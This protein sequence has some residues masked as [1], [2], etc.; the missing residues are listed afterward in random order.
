[1]FFGGGQTLKEKADVLRQQLGLSEG[2]P[3][4]SVVDKATAELGLSNELEGLNLQQKVDACLSRLGVSDVPAA[5]AV[6]L[7][8]A[9]A[10][11]VT[12]AVLMGTPVGEHEQVQPVVAIPAVPEAPR[13]T[14]RLKLA[15]RDGRGLALHHDSVDATHGRRA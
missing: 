13:S 11:V 2:D 12:D 6:P 9:M 3:L 4:V 7:Q 15:L 5:Q 10:V 1:M 8:P 14:N